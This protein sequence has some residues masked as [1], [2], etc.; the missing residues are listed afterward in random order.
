VPISVSTQRCLLNGAY[1]EDRQRS[2]EAFKKES[3]A[4]QEA[5]KQEAEAREDRQR[6]AE[7][8]K[9]ESEAREEAFKKESES[10]ACR[11]QYDPNAVMSVGTAR[12]LRGCLACSLSLPSTANAPHLA[13]SLGQSCGPLSTQLNTAQRRQIECRL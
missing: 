8:F 1:S 2:A 3:E 7:A 11:R 6:S 10:V 5:V 4:R 9:K 13:C 12:I